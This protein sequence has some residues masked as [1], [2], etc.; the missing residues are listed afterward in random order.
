MSEKVV[1]TGG[2]GFIGSHLVKKLVQEG[3]EVTIFDWLQLDYG[4]LENLKEVSSE[5]NFIRGDISDFSSVVEALKGARTV[6]HLAAISHLPICHAN[7]LRAFEVNFGGTLN[8]LEACRANGVERVV[9]AG[10]DHVYGSAQY[11][12]IDEK[13]PYNPRDA[14]A[15]SKAQSIELCRLYQRNYGLDTRI[16]ISGNVFGEFQDHSKVVPIFIKQALK[17]HT[18]TVDGGAQ[19]RGFYHVANLVNA[20]LLVA[21]APD[22]KGETFNVDGDDEVSIRSLAE[23]IISLTESHSELVIRDYRYDEDPLMRL[24]MDKS[25]IAQ[26]GYTTEVGFEEGLKRI[27]EWYRIN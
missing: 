16:L 21:K 23:K 12:P 20:Y 5:I 27:I 1:V 14:Y 22:L 3:S 15:L 26:L 17:N 8:V 18:L 24:F 4:K 7:P 2:A 6:L 9:F 13:H 10:S 25:K 11:L 19:T